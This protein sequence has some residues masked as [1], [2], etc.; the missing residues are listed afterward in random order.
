MSTRLVCK[1]TTNSLNNF[2]NNNNVRNV[3]FN[4]ILKQIKLNRIFFKY[5][6][7]P[8]FK[9]Y[10]KREITIGENKEQK[11]ETTKHLIRGDWNGQLS[12]WNIDNVKPI[13]NFKD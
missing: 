6:G 3:I 8:I 12:I 1:F 11:V 2:E 9:L 4:F 13:G 10:E 7:T 5:F